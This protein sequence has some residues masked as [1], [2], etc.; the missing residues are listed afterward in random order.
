MHGFRV[1]TFCGRED[2]LFKVV[3]LG[4]PFAS[5][6]VFQSHFS[7]AQRFQY[8]PVPMSFWNED[9]AGLL[10]AR[11]LRHRGGGLRDGRLGFDTLREIRAR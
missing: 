2:S 4:I 1:D 9:D 5:T 7:S 10:H 8:G 3:I 11:D 6:V